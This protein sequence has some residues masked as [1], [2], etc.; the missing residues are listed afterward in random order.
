MGIQA[1]PAPQNGGGRDV[2]ERQREGD[3]YPGPL[4]LPTSPP[5]PAPRPVLLIF[6][7]VPPAPQPPNSAPL[8]ARAQRPPGPP[9]PELSAPRSGCAA[10]PPR[11]RTRRPGPPRSIRP[12]GKP[13]TLILTAAGLC[14]VMVTPPPATPP[15]PSPSLR[16]GGAEPGPAGTNGRTRRAVAGAMAGCGVAVLPQ[17]SVRLQT[18]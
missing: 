3:P 11:S 14:L 5:Q 12:G 16:H 15:P 13:G 1:T 6:T 2:R 9:A 10:S 4:L 18:V 17:G 8:S 7:S